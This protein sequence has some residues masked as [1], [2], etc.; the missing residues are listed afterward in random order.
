MRFVMESFVMKYL[1]IDRGVLLDVDDEPVRCSV[2]WY[3]IRCG[4]YG[5]VLVIFLWNSH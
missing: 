1:C 4:Q 5:F 3:S 2:Q